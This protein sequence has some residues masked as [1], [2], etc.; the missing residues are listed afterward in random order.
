MGLS[1]FPWSCFISLSLEGSSLEKRG[2]DLGLESQLMD[3]DAKISRAA[4]RPKKHRCFGTLRGP[5][6]VQMLPIR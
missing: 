5:E 6:S 2:Q 1:D 4:I 3:T